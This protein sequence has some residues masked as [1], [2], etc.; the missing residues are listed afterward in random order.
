MARNLDEI[1]TM[2]KALLDELSHED[3]VKILSE[4]SLGA[5]DFIVDEAP[6]PERVAEIERR[7]NDADP[8]HWR[9]WEDVELDVFSPEARAAVQRLT[10][11]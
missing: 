6:T 1:R 3:Q 8:G 4:L 11:R 2:V 10:T 9:S 7:A 5:T